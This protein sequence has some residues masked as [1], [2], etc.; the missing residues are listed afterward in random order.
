MTLIAKVKNSFCIVVIKIEKEETAWERGRF[1]A[2]M[3]V[4]IQKS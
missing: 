2:S 1:E 3:I 4:Y